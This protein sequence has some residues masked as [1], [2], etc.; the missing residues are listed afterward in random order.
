MTTEEILDLCE[1][2]GVEIYTRYDFISD[3]LI[4]RMEKGQRDIERAISAW[5]VHSAGFGLTLRI[6]LRGM[7][8][9]LDKEAEHEQN[10]N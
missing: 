1:K 5:D 3:A 7:A 6:I 10:K 9:E 4:I 2:R 8:D